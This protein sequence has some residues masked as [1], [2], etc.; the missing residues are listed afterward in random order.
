MSRWACYIEEYNT[1]NGIAARLR[2]KKTGKK[3]SIKIDSLV[4]KKHF[5]RFLSAA[6]SNKTIM[7]TIFDP[8][9]D[10]VVA[11]YGVKWKENRNTIFVDTHN[12]GYLFE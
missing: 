12:G 2:D 7:P 3:I 8:C 5:L 9:G 1:T 4:E 11:V 6:V 10:D